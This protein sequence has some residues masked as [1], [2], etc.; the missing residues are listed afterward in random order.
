MEA[1]ELGW[2]EWEHS[3]GEAFAC[4]LWLG[5]ATWLLERECSGFALHLSRSGQRVKVAWFRDPGTPEAAR[6]QALVRVRDW[7][8]QGLRHLA[9]LAP[10]VAAEEAGAAA[11]PPDVSA[12]TAEIVGSAESETGPAQAAWTALAE[13]VHELAAGRAAQINNA[14]LA[15]QAE[16]L[17][18]GGVPAEEVCRALAED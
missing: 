4:V 12:R 5:E 6:E 14:G 16:F 7:H 9:A 11:V 17:L 3:G 1:M 2:S 10:D 8:R 15:R 18:S 13:M